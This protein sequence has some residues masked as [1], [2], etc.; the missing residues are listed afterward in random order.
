MRVWPVM[1]GLI[2]AGLGLVVLLGW[3]A[4]IAVLKSILPQWATMKFN[5]AACF[6]MGGLALLLSRT[7]V[8]KKSRR[9]GLGFAGAITVMA[10]LTLSQYIF[11][12]DLGID[13]LFWSSNQDITQT[14]APGRMSPVTAFCFMLLGLALLTL[15]WKTP[16]GRRPAL[17]PALIVAFTGL[18]V[19]AGYLYG[20][21]SLYSLST[22]S[23]IALHTAICLM[24]LASGI[25]CSRQGN[26]LLQILTSPG[27]GGGLLRRM[28]PVAILAPLTMG[29]L[30]LMGERA[31]LYGFEFGLAIFAISNVLIFSIL[32]WLTARWLN[33]TDFARQESE[34]HYRQLIECLPQLVWTCRA[35]GPCDYLSPQWVEYTG[36]PG[37]KQLKYGWLEQIHPED[38]E[39]TIRRWKETAGKGVPLDIEFRIRRHDGMY[40]WF[41][42][43]AVPLLN[44]KGEIIKWLGTNTDIDDAKQAEGDRARLAAIVDSTTDAIVG[45]TL[46]G[47]VTSWNSGA[48]TIFGYSKQEILGQSIKQI[49][50]PE[51]H[52]LEET[53][54][55]RLG[56]GE[57]MQHF[58]TLRR[59]KNGQ[60][61]PISLALSPVLNDRGQVVGI[62]KVARD[63]TER[64]RIEREISQ[65]REILEERVRE[66]TLELSESNEALQRNT[67]LLIEAQKI[68]SLG[69]WILDLISNE[70]EWTEEL[71]RIMG[72]DPK[73]QAPNYQDQEKMFTAESWSRLVSAVSHSISTGEGY[74]LELEVVRP[75]RQKCWAVARGVTT[76][77]AKGQVIRLGGT[78]QD[79]TEL[80][81]MD[82]ALYEQ[83]SQLERSNK[84]LEQFAYVA[85]HDLQEP[86]RAVSGCVQIFQSR[87]AGQLDAG[88]DELITHIVEGASRMQTLIHDLLTYS[89]VATHEKSLSLVDAEEALGQAVGHLKSSIEESGARI[90]SGV[91]PKVRMAS[92]QLVQLFQNLIGN[93]I[94][95]R[96]SEPPEIRV[97]ATRK[98]RN[99]EFS[100]RDNGIGIQAQYFDRIFILFQRLHTRREYSGTGIGLAL[101]KKIVEHHGGRIWLESEPGKGSTFYFTLPLDN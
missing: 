79:I 16:G 47:V 25:L 8:S 97:E 66:R 61:I 92:S 69:S 22:F 37:S 57:K 94:K 23:S 89:R 62:S 30:R 99:W 32:I 2:V 3:V 18:L 55:N 1:A 50:P 87:Y 52:G 73:S 21:R 86:L 48:E 82:L 15:D 24:I 53:I 85:S 81:K 40:R 46:E 43:R 63:I 34:A 45:M 33:R 93:G 74:Q 9:I 5:T 78:F 4:D 41:K 54:L 29:W 96:N 10:G 80:K 64:L 72:L 75:D 36:I 65:S 58:R 71:F 26:D 7:Q 44:V 59:H 70:V 60:L 77:N 6:L 38:Q 101:C 84:D 68:A 17:I 49:I 91:L 56:N 12:R 90:S 31:G 11:S 98:E 35:D 83:K 100:V 95:Y 20:V 19:C 42:T 88:A 51:K 28:L 76:R 14:S 39:R 27:V 67:N 13:Q